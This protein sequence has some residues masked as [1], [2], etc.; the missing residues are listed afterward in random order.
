MRIALEEVQTGAMPGVS[1][2]DF[3][4]VSVSVVRVSAYVGLLFIKG[5]V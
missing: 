5:R 1:V 4:L 3:G 2:H